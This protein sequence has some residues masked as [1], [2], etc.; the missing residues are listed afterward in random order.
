LKDK[1]KNLRDLASLVRT[2]DT[3]HHSAKTKST[4]NPLHEAV[5][6]IMLREKEKTFVKHR[7]VATLVENYLAGQGSFYRTQD[8]R[9][10]YFDSGE[11][12]LFDM[13]QRRFMHFLTDTA[14]LSSTETVFKFVLD[15]LQ[16]NVAFRGQLTEIYTLSYYDPPTGLVVVSNGGGGVWLREVGG[17]WVEAKNGENGVLFLTDLDATAWVPEFSS[18]EGDSLRWLLE[19]IPFSGETLDKETA[20]TFLLVWLLQQFFPS[21]RRTRMIPTFLGPH[22]SGK[23]TACRLLGRTLVGES[24]DVSGLRREKEDAFIAAMTNRVVFTVDNADTRVDWLED[25][26]ARYATGEKYRMRRLY[27][28]NDEVSYTPRANLLLT[29][30]DPHFNR[31]DVSE[32]LLPLHLSRLAEFIDEGSLYQDLSDRRG[33]ILG[34]ILTRIAHAADALSIGPAPTMRFRM[35]DYASFGW[36]I[37][38]PIGKD[39]EWLEAI[40]SLHKVQMS[41]AAEGDGMISALGML[42][43]NESEVGPISVRDLYS[44]IQEIAESERVSIPNSV[45]GFG[46]KLTSHKRIIEMELNVAYSEDRGH[47]RKRWITLKR[48]TLSKTPSPPSPTSPKMDTVENMES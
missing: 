17:E 47:G 33:L 6:N 14:N 39:R 9:L 10:F 1:I 16:A 25:A 4:N 5:R 22:G 34:D 29:S 27:T 18:K 40:D 3:L 32:R 37:L 42:L 15:I 31:P 43:E 12:K 13:Q 24:F 30:R 36:R 19:L 44:K 26:L 23:T 2:T 38:R 46:K 41:F 7:E 45:D 11:H 28:T 48:K 8:E 35:A 20:Q 21:L